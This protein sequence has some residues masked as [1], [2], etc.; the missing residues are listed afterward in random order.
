MTGS[1]SAR[2]CGMRAYVTYLI[3]LNHRDTPSFFRSFICKILFCMS[4][5]LSTRRFGRIDY[6]IVNTG[7]TV[8]S[9]IYIKL[10]IHI[11]YFFYPFVSVGR[12]GIA[13]KHCNYHAYDTRQPY[14]SLAVCVVS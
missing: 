6:Y 11:N 14:R 9:N 7:T 13:S 5:I 8:V 4:L 10:I 12:D 1:E 3:K 2:K